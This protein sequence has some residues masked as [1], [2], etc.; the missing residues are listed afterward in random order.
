MPACLPA[1]LVGHP[2]GLIQ[3]NRLR[4]HV[5][6]CARAPACLRDSLGTPVELMNDDGMRGVYVPDFSTATGRSLWL[7][8]VQG[9]PH[10]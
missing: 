8:T 10:L 1:W 3:R 7:S 4:V 6:T 9:K 5:C 2:R